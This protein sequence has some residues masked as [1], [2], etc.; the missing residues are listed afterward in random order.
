MHWDAVP[1]VNSSKN[2]LVVDGLG[3]FPLIYR[4]GWM[5]GR[6]ADTVRAA[7]N[8]TWPLWKVRLFLLTLEIRRTRQRS[9]GWIYDYLDTINEPDKRIL[10][11]ILGV[12]VAGLGEPSGRTHRPILSRRVRNIRG[13]VRLAQRNGV[14]DEFGAVAQE[15]RADADMLPVEIRAHLIFPGSNGPLCSRSVRGGCRMAYLDLTPMLQAMRA[16]PSEFEVNGPFLR[17]IRSQHLLEVDRRGNVL[18]HARCDRARLEVSREQGE[19][20]MAALSAWKIVYW[21]PHLAQVEAEKRAAK[22]NREF[23]S[24]FRPPGAWRRFLAVFRRNDNLLSS[25]IED[26][27]IEKRKGSNRRKRCLG[28]PELL[29]R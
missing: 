5:D 1:S 13:C 6:R 28:Q 24:H 2:H 18:V 22:I 26:R 29:R 27:P 17:H 14:G 20:M 25:I 9:D 8:V 19:E 7:L 3:I 4:S 11:L 10:Q 21:E 15:A 12:F 16:R 23:A